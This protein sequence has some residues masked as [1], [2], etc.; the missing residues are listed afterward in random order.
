MRCKRCKQTWGIVRGQVDRE[1]T[2]SP[3]DHQ[4]CYA[5]PPLSIGDWPDQFFITKWIHP[6][7]LD[8]QFLRID[9]RYWVPVIS[10]LIIRTGRSFS[11]CLSP[12]LFVNKI[13]LMESSV[14]DPD[15]DPSVRGPDPGSG[16]SPNCH[17]SPTLMESTAHYFSG[18]MFYKLQSSAYFLKGSLSRD[19]RF[20]VFFHPR[21]SDN[22]LSVIDI[23]GTSSYECLREFSKIG[24]PMVGIYKSLTETWNGNWER[25]RAV[26][27]LGNINGIF[28]TV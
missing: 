2:V 24:R 5:E 18:V 11:F 8:D 17:W 27:F 25:G 9:Y 26:S 16:S 21:A 14:G 6:S 15:P 4:Q 23:S 22:S 13:C 1:R 28:G 20:Q 12:C 10:Y 3:S 7:T 19:F